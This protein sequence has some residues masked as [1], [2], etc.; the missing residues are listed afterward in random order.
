MPPSTN[1]ITLRLCL[2]IVLLREES[3]RFPRLKDPKPRPLQQQLCVDFPLGA[4]EVVDLG[5]VAMFTSP[6]YSYLH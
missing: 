4:E 5:I 1:W 3:Y 2:G 6:M